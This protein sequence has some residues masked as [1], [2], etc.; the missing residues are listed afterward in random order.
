MDLDRP[1]RLDRLTDV[2]IWSLAI[3]HD[4][5]DRPDRF[6]DNPGNR[7]RL[8][9]PEMFPHDRPDRLSKFGAIMVFMW[10]VVLCHYT[11]H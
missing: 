10:S 6:A 2:S 1:D 5:L 8:D 4:R 3:I 7:D 9:H 11:T